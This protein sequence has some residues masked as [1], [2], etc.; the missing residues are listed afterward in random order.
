MC[1]KVSDSVFCV[2]AS[3][4]AALGAFLIAMAE[5]ETGAQVLES[6][7]S[8]MDD[9]G[10]ISEMIGNNRKTQLANVEPSI[11]WLIS[12]LG[13]GKGFLE[14]I[15]PSAWR[16]NVYRHYHPNWAHMGGI[17][18]RNLAYNHL[19]SGYLKR[20]ALLLGRPAKELERLD[21][22]AFDCELAVNAMWD[23]SRGFYRRAYD[24][25]LK[26]FSPFTHSETFVAL[27]KA[28]RPARREELLKKIPEHFLSKSGAL[29]SYPLGLDG[30]EP[31]NDKE[32][33][34]ILK[35]SNY[36]FVM[37]ALKKHAPELFERV[38]GGV[39]K[40]IADD[41]DFWEEH[42]LYG[43]GY[44]NG[45]GSVFGAFGFIWTALCLDGRAQSLLDDKDFL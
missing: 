6:V 42:D 35:P 33:R 15:Y 13:A 21:S 10:F 44:N 39:M 5:P 22:M 9:D 29:R 2:P 40:A 1:N 41:G 38:A 34:S 17:A 24:P 12:S 3:W 28:A 43:R 37:P 8:T 31:K 19:A 26:T 16:N 4:E 25:V 27:G 20:A 36:L 45:P 11:A 7:Y 30:A 14:R 18:C 23:A 32:W